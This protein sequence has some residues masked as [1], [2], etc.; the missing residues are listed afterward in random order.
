MVRVL[1]TGGTGLV[2][3]ELC[4]K[5]VEKGYEAGILS[6]K[7]EH[8]VNYKTYYWDP[9]KNEIDKEAVESADYIIHL[10]GA[11]LSNQRWTD[12]RKRMIISSRI[13]TAELLYMKVSQSRNK[14]AAFISASAVNYYGTITSDKIFSEDDPPG[15]DFLGET[16][17]KWE[18][19]AMKFDKDGIRTVIIRTGVVLSSKGGALPRMMQPV[20][21][22]LGAPIG[23]GRQYMP[24]IHIDDICNI[25]IRAIEDAQ[26]NGPFNGVAPDHITNKDFMKTL[27]RVNDKPF[28]APNAPALALKIIYGKMADV[29]LKGSR[30]SSVRIRTAGYNFLYPE[31]DKAVNDLLKSSK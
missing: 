17:R 8:D 5:L 3:R 26:M 9:G 19:S 6:R 18:E 31:L 22:G 11:N 25:Y 7:K 13:D 15:N 23:S 27:A 10:A 24:W 20:T 29:V 28:F 2:G 4:K 30:V 16:C 21:L 12:E 14:P 1:I